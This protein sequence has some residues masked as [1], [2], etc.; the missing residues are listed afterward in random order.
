MKSKKQIPLP[1]TRSFVKTVKKF[2]GQITHVSFDHDLVAKHYE[3]HKQK[4]FI[5]YDSEGFNENRNKTGYHAAKHLKEVLGN[6][7]WSFR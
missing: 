3:P 4:G 7:S 2:K 5:D 6:T 1:K